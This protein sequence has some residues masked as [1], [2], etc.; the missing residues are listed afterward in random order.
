MIA[1]CKNAN[2][3]FSLCLL[4]MPIRSKPL[5][6]LHSIKDNTVT[7][8]KGAGDIAIS[9][10]GLPKVFAPFIQLLLVDRQIE[11]DELR[12][13]LDRLFDELY[14][15]PLSEQS[16]S[17]TAYLRRY[18]ILPNE[19]STENL[20]RYLVK[21]VV[22]RSP[23]D[24]P[25][26]VIDEFWGFF[27]ELIESPELR[28]LVELNL[29]ITRSVLKSYEPL[30]LDII[31]SIKHIRNINQRTLSEIV[32]KL[33]VLKGDIRILRRQIKA[34]RHIKPFLQTDPKDFK[35]Q[36]EIVAQ[37]VREFGPL[38]I[39]M[40]QVAAA[41][42]DFLPQE[43][44]SEL[45]VFQED[46]APMTA[47]EVYQAFSEDYG[48]M[49]EARYFGFNVNSPIKSGSIGSVFVAKK[50]IIK[51]DGEEL[52]VPVVVKVARHNL[53]REFAMGSLA[54]E[55]ML[56]SSQYWAPHSKL[57]PFLS[58]M[59]D[60]IKEFTK[61]FAQELDFNHEAEVQ[62]RFFQR[63]QHSNVWFVPKLY[64]GTGRILEMEYIEGANAI[65]QALSIFDGKRKRRFQRRLSESFLYT[66]LE[67]LLIH[68]EFHGD[69]H[70][71]NIMVD[72]EA[73]LFL[74]DWGNAVDMKGKWPLIWR[75]V[76]SVFASD[77]ATL[78]QTLIDMSTNPSSNTKRLQE[79]QS[80]LN[81]TLNKKDIAPLGKDF[82]LSLYQE[83][84]PGLQVRLNTAAHLMTN[85]YQLGITIHSD[86]LHLSRS[87]FAMAGTYNNINQGVS[88]W[89]MGRH[90]LTDV[91]SFPFKY[92]LS[93]IIRPA[94]GA[95]KNGA[96][97]DKINQQLAL[98]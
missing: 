35:T 27:Q 1:A 20:I 9:S 12:F 97:D 69:L 64:G 36:A 66:M 2:Q 50:P 53:E 98:S 30:L 91:V 71:G 65:N 72:G 16:R 17:L 79:I 13:E 92:T 10:I 22:L 68:N 93:N 18:R 24:I 52:L 74:I 86:Y 73:R 41:N 11:A 80:A 45:Q 43:I 70:P 51:V 57:K 49:P 83:G 96:T 8:L 19:D 15:H 88:G 21:Q 84:L 29:E 33:Q 47:D 58:S 67:H 63:S 76:F 78:A 54:I 6:N 7:V 23:V 40:A 32:Q 77:T 31:N 95:K 81:E 5:I 90:F 28:G 48:E 89:A 4:F 14:Q 25:E 75:Y 34:I 37:M 39:K 46:V 62:D 55:L 59:S 44:A 61:G 56:I 82:A 26:V 85:S 42:S 3:L 38:F 60:Q 87:L 94:L